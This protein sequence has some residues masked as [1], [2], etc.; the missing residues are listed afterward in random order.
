[1]AHVI[2]FAIVPF[3]SSLTVKGHTKSLEARERDEQ[4]GKTESTD[5]G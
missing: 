3:I 4:F 2:Q 5:I 1:M